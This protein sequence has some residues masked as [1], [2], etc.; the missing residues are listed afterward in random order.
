MKKYLQLLESLNLTV[1]GL[2]SSL[3]KRIKNYEALLEAIEEEK[4]A[5]EKTTS[6]SKRAQLQEDI[7]LGEQRAQ[8]EEEEICAGIERWNRNKD[9]Y[10]ENAKRLKR[11]SAAPSAS[12]PPVNEPPAN[13]PPAGDPPSGDPPANEPPVN[14]P[15]AGDPPANDPPAGD[16]PAGDP[17]S[18]DPPAGDP[19]TKDKKKKKTGVWGVLGVV[20]AIGLAAVGYNYYKNQ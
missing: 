20:A 8:Q 13:D 12:E 1:S 5:L 16:P 2:S 19:P 11:G 9:I 17:P 7:A 10:A 3:K 4:L 14:E 6:E 18:G 15:P